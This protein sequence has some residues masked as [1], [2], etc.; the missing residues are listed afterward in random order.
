MV[1]KHLEL[2]KE[3]VPNLSRVAVLSNPANPM[4]VVRLREVEIA[5]RLSKAPIIGITGS[6]GKTTTTSL[7]GEMLKNAQ[8]PRTVA[9]N[10]G[11]ALVD[12]V[13]SISPDEWLVAELSSF[14]LKGTSLFRPKIGALLNVFPAHLDWHQSMDDYITSKSRLFQNQTE[15]DVAIFNADQPLSSEIAERVSSQVWWF[16]RLKV[17]E[18]G[19]YVLGDMICAKLPGKDPLEILPVGEVSLRGSFNLENMLAATAISLAAGVPVSAIQET[20]RTFPGVEHRLEYVKTINGVKYYN[21]S[22]ATNAQAATKALES[23]TEPI[24]WIA[25]GLDRGVDFKEMVPVMK[26][27]VKA[28]VTYGQTKEIFAARAKDAGLAHIQVVQDVQEAAQM[29]SEIA[30]AGDVVLL[31]PACASWDQH[32]SFEQRGS[33]FKQ[34]V[35]SLQI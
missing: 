3:A 8:M 30:E 16:S 7:V 18:P 31:S 27:R 26:Q 13:E 9:G 19:V 14:Q 20:L 25:G 5:G 21:D 4:H 35:H 29:A 24:V 2:L 22:K 12:V 28:L 15:Q 33:I 23:F 17:V 1:G 32:A 34:A 11:K 10:I 6:N